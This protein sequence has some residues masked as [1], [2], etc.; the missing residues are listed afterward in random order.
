MN[1]QKGTLVNKLSSQIILA[2]NKKALF[3]YEVLSRLTAGIVL[4][5]WEVASLRRGQCNLR[6]SFIF[7]DAQRVVVEG[8]HISLYQPSGVQTIG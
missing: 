4:Q 2:S 6:G 3:D 1:N 5:G 8:M 7:I